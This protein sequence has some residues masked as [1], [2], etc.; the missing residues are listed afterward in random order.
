[1]KAERIW[2]AQAR[3]KAPQRFCLKRGTYGETKRA[4]AGFQTFSPRIDPK[5]KNKH[6]IARPA[7]G[8]D[9]AAKGWIRTI[10]PQVKAA[11]HWCVI[12]LP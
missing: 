3:D 5:Q 7:F 12:R 11:C 8:A 10:A 1:M 6:T 9:I 2:V 4:S